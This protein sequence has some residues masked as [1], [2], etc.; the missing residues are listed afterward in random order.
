MQVVAITSLLAVLGWWRVRGFKWER[1][2]FRTEFQ[3][4]KLPK[5][6]MIRM[7]GLIWTNKNEEHRL[8]LMSKTS[9]PLLFL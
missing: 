4:C 5:D 9:F 8:M 2:S 3:I 1:A 7:Y 6:S